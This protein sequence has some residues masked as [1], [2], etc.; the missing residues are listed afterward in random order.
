VPVSDSAPVGGHPALDL[1]NT[2]EWRGDPARRCDRLDGD[3]AL[4]AWVAQHD[5]VP[6]DDLERLRGEASAPGVVG[7]V[8]ALREALHAV[9]LDAVLLEH[10]AEGPRE[11]VHRAI[12]DATAR[13]R[14]GRELPWRWRLEEPHREDLPALAA[15]AAADL[16]TSSAVEDVRRCEDT[17]CGWLFLDRTRNR[18]RRWCSSS[19][20]GNRARVRR[21][22][23]RSRTT[24]EQGVAGPPGG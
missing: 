20:C 17:A 19:T 23:V 5:L 10:P 9:L 2:V 11:A 13:A 4:L 16:L 22:S 7:A 1:I 14:P 8:R 21:H 12:A 15:L 3:D 24:P 18:S 6:A